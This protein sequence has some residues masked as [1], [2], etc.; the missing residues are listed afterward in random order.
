VPTKIAA[1]RTP[2]ARQRSLTRIQHAGRVRTEILAIAG[3]AML[4]FAHSKN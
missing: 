1:V 2:L 4:S 3:K